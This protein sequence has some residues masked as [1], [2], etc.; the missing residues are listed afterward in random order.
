MA[1]GGG[2]RGFLPAIVTPLNAD[3]TVDVPS[4]RRLARHMFDEG[5]A[6]LYVGGEID[7]CPHSPSQSEFQWHRLTFTHTL[8][9]PLAH[10]LSVCLSLSLSL[11]LFHSID[12][13]FVRSLTR[14]LAHSQFDLSVSHHH[15][16]VHAFASLTRSHSLT[17][18]LAP[19]SLSLPLLVHPRT[20]AH[21]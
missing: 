8:T 2:L 12:H 6:G 16:L 20:S 18:L 9:R 19:L 10:S 5:V 1:S 13:R 17:H 11:E 21:R 7:A 3:K 14:S 4:I 15:Q